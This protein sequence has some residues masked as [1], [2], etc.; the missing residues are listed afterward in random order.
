MLRTGVTTA[1]CVDQLLRAAG[2]RAQ[3]VASCDVPLTQISERD[4]CGGFSV[5]RSLQS[6]CSLRRWKVG[7]TRVRCLMKALQC[8]WVCRKEVACML[9]LKIQEPGAGGQFAVCIV[10]H[11]QGGFRNN[12]CCCSASRRA[13]LGVLGCPSVHS[14]RQQTADSSRPQPAQD[15]W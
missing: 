8:R 13:G 14:T 15:L 12:A 9:K 4:L 11:Y 10:A 6:R 7:S 3:V 1:R 2:G 5:R